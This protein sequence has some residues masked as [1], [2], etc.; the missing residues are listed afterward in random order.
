[1]ASPTG[2]KWGIYDERYYNADSL[3]LF[4]SLVAGGAFGTSFSNYYRDI[5]RG[6]GYS[7]SEK[8]N[9][10]MEEERRNN[11]DLVTKLIRAYKDSHIDNP[12]QDISLYTD[13]GERMAARVGV[14]DWREIDVSPSGHPELAE[15]YSLME[16]CAYA[17]SFTTKMDQNRRDAEAKLKA[18]AA[19]IATPAAENG[20]L[21]VQDGS[22]V[23][24]WKNIPGYDMIRQSLKGGT[25][26]KVELSTDNFSSGE[27][28]IHFASSASARARFL[29]FFKG[30]AEHGREYDFS[31]YAAADST[32]KASIAFDG[33]T[34]ISATPAE[35]SAD[36]KQ[37]WFNS[38]ILSEI[39]RNSVSLDTGYKFVSSEF[40][41][42]EVFGKDGKLCRLR[43]FVISQQ[44]SLHL[45]FAK[46][47]CDEMK[48]FFTQEA[49]ASFSI[50]GGVISGSRSSGYS[51]K[52]Y[53]YSESEQKVSV[54]IVPPDVESGTMF[55]RTAFLLGGVVEHYE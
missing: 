16:D 24:G 35:L 20:G 12:P 9:A 47:S 29:V 22:C 46:F 15:L 26:I 45:E 10:R 51:F 55:E 32:V 44:P 13:V 3:L 43:T 36:N 53:S 27:C 6:T 38:S 37:G 39:A 11:D 4:D 28:D 49:S 42:D 23:V 18:I 17:L 50:L 54:D 14:D 25:S 52:N 1:M 19:N 21:P 30:A 5:I 31:K 33:I 34:F 8:D 2:F 41:P 40:K 7:F 48:E